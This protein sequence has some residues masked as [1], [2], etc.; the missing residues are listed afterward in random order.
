LAVF[1]DRPTLDFWAAKTWA[2]K[3]THDYQAAN[4]ARSMDGL[5]GLRVARRDAGEWV[6]AGDIAAWTNRL[7]AEKSAVAFGFFLAVFTYVC[8]SAAF[9]FGACETSGHLLFR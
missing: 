6:R 7:L 3:K 2:A 9:G 1:T 8:L 5:P 4:N